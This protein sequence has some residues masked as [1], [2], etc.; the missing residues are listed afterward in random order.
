MCTYL[1]VLLPCPFGEQASLDT[2][3]LMGLAPG[4]ATEYWRWSGADFCGDL[5][6]WTH[7]LLAVAAP[8]Y[9]SSI[10]YGYQGE[11]EDLGCAASDVEVCASPCDV[12]KVWVEV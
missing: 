3:Y 12:G 5:Y 9:V 1:A 8:P 7:T 6:N 4:I 10:S 2:Q 11:L